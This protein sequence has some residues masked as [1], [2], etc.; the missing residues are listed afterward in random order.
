MGGKRDENL[1]DDLDFGDADDS[2]DSLD[3]ASDEKLAGVSFSPRSRRNWRD[4][5]RAREEREMRRL[6]GA[7]D[8]WMDELDDSPS[9]HRR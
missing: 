8:D 5:E 1:D 4:V 3:D 6:M 9:I 7:V 2:M